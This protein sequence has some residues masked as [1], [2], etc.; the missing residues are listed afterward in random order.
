MCGIAGFWALDNGP[1]G[2][3]ADAVLRRMADTI[4]HRGPDAA[5]YWSDAESGIALAHRR[6]SILDLSPAG[7]QPM[8]SASGRFV[9]IFNGEIYNHLTL[10]TEL[11]AAGAAPPWHGHSDTETLLA[12][13]E[14]HGVEAALKQ[15]FGMFAFALWDKRERQLTLA[16]DRIGEKP[17]YFGPVGKHLVFASELKA[18][19]R[20]PGFTG[21][22]D[23]EALA[24][25]LQVSYVPSPFTIYEGIGKLEPGTFA[26]FRS[27]ATEPEIRA[28]WSLDEVIGNTA[29]QRNAQPTFEESVARLDT[30]L[31]D[32]TRSQMLSDVPLGAFLSGGIDSSLITAIMQEQSSQPVR[33]YS[34]GFDDPHFNEAEAAAAVARHLGTCHTS[35]TVTERDALEL[36]PSLPE[37]YDEPF[38][39]SSQL[40]TTLLCSL[41]SQHVRVAL[42]GDGGDEIFGGYNRHR[43]APKIW[44]R[45]RPI[46]RILRKAG[47]ATALQLERRLVQSDWLYRALKSAGMPLSLLDKVGRFARAVGQSSDF[48]EFYRQLIVTGAALSANKAVSLPRLGPLPLDLSLSEQVM[49]WDT[50]TYLPDDILVKVDRAAMRSSLETRAP[51]IDSR[52]IDVAWSMPISHRIGAHGGKSPLKELLYRRFPRELIERPKQGFSIPLNAWLRGGLRDWAQGL[53]EEFAGRQPESAAIRGLWERHQTGR[54]ANG[55]AIWN[56]AMFEAWIKFNNSQIQSGV[57]DQY[58]DSVFAKGEFIATDEASL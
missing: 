20:F 50:L 1:R 58:A 5:G 24:M 49:R 40:P 39:D 14:R 36:I 56:I 18:M 12:M 52:V 11:E 6:L 22:I 32:V 44:N 42:S 57:I 28:Y 55:E 41:T 26:T 19:Q 51:F 21:A 13:I 34:I 15:A 7:A 53:V 25:F 43:L 16:R 10:R 4:V 27:P 31:A 3:A 30:V 48:S 35:F 33:T 9:I 2:T 46:P 17:L 54:Q 29:A 47:A 45:L 37:S 38:A 23:S 8:H